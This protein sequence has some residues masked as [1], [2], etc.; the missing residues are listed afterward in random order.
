MD[1]G[2]LVQ[3]LQV[4]A[5]ESR[6]INSKQA[7]EQLKQL[8]QVP[9]FHYNLQTIYLNTNYPLQV[10]WLAIICFKN[11]VDQYWRPTR[12][13]AISKQEKDSIKSRLFELL[14]VNGNQLTIQNAQAI[15]RIVRYDFPHEWPN[16]F[17]QLEGLLNSTNYVYLHNI[18][19]ILN[20]IIKTVGSI[21]VGRARATMQ[22]KVPILTP[23]LIKLYEQFF[24][25]WSRD[26]NLASVEVG[27]LSLKCIRRIIDV[28]SEFH[29]RDD[30]VKHFFNLSLRH[31]RLLLNERDRQEI[32][33]VERYIK[34]YTKIYLSVL[35]NNPTSFILLDG[36]S[37][38]LITMLSILENKADL[39]YNSR[40]DSDETSFWEQLAI[41][42]LLMLKKLV[43][44]VY[45]KGAL[46]L[47]KQHD[48]AEVEK[49]IRVLTTKFFTESLVANLI[50][51][52]IKNYLRLRPEDLELWS[53]DPE[54]WAN[55]ELTN[56]WEY[57]IR[58]CAENFFRDLVTHF[59]ETRNFVLVRINE[60]DPS[61]NS[62][63]SEVLTKDALLSAFQLSS[64]SL[65]NDV[66][67]DNLLT[68]VF[69]PLVEQNQPILVRRILLIISEWISINCSKQSR[70]LIY[71][72]LLSL[73][74]SS[75]DRI[76]RI[77][78]VQT[79]RYAIDDYDF[80][81]TDF[82]PYAEHV[83]AHL[84]GL[85]SAMKLTE[86]KLNVMNVLSILLEQCNSIIPRN[87][88]FDVLSLVTKVWGSSE[89]ILKAAFLRLL[90]NVCAC[91]KSD[92]TETYSITLPLIE[93]CC[94]ESSEEYTILSEDGY[95]LWLEVLRS[96]PEPIPSRL[97]DIFPLI[98][99]AL[100]NSTEILPTILSIIR[101][102][103]L[104]DPTLFEHD[105]GL[106]IFK[107]MGQYLPNMR[108]DALNIFMSILDIF[109]LQ[110]QR[111]HNQL[112]NSLLTTQFME[113]GLL[114]SLLTFALN[115]DEAVITSNKVLIPLSRFLYIG[116]HLLK[117]MIDHISRH[118]NTQIFNQLYSLM[119][120][121]IDYLGD[122]RNR[123]SFLLALLSPYL[124]IE[125]D[126]DF[127]F[128]I[129][130]FAPL[131]AEVTKQFEEIN[132][133]L[134]GDCQ[135]YHRSYS[136]EGLEF[137][138]QDRNELLRVNKLL[139]LDPIHCLP[140]K[141]QVSK[142][143]NHL[144]QVLGARFDEVVKTLDPSSLDQLKRL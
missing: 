70:Q 76:V 30:D 3:L 125:M 56:S 103:I 108:D 114:E 89:T 122:P 106:Q 17:E 123:K 72:L 120:K 90:K 99:P 46:T 2:G 101:S 107:I 77:T 75:Q 25:S 44:F 48:K 135:V 95:E 5:D 51:L 119:L 111:T 47:K 142:V 137:L 79:L 131:M 42:S 105:T 35:N 88:L 27:Y 109:F 61:P 110:L 128:L 141:E 4:S 49:A 86:S 38:I 144:K 69:I 68:S 39:I 133:T 124:T 59:Q 50:D 130:N 100:L 96:I 34:C 10:R 63:L 115:T 12:K 19:V 129:S 102:Y 24:Q 92:V 97:V 62:N 126:S 23:H 73:L 1:L 26:F 32:S 41:N 54:Q 20:Q 53:E 118:Q 116:P 57:Q 15:S 29:D 7:E 83:I 58:P 22:A 91:L 28:V 71:K 143:L 55:D 78:A 121:R 31:L 138:P 45:R 140:L 139:E 21:K 14:E 9:G 6:G 81:R 94:S 132:E 40:E 74:Q 18:L 85:V 16:L 104:L 43:N 64:A 65:A 11:G 84:I 98:V 93:T 37:D 13:F 127:E 134:S 136:Y 67:F 8:E 66:N 117:E 60:F 80:D 33:I 87:S 82:Q 52:I 112:E 113:S 36:A